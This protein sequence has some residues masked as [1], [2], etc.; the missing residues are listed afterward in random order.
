[1]IERDAIETSRER[2]WNTRPLISFFATMAFLFMIFFFS[3]I[4]PFSGTSGKSVLISDLS[5]QYAPFLVS[6]RNSILHGRSLT[7]SFQIGMGKNYLG[8]FAYYLSSPI[9]LVALLFPVSHISDAIV[10]IITLK[11]SL[12][13]AFM[14]WLLDKRFQDKTKM[15]ILFGS[16]YALCSFALVFMMNFMW[17]DGFALLPLVILV[18]EQFRKDTRQWWKVFIVLTILF[19][20]GYYMAYM[21]GVFSFFYLIAL[22]DYEGFFSKDRDPSGAKV[23][24]L[25]VLAAVFAA[26]VCA[27]MLIPAGLDTIY[28][29]D[30]SAATTPSVIP[31]F[32]LISFLPQLFLTRL[33]DIADNPPFIYAD[34]ATLFLVILFF[35]N[36]E[37]SSRLKRWCGIA[38]GL[39]V[40]SFMLPPLDIAWQLFDEPN[41][42]MHRYSYILTFG[43]ILI[44]FYSYLHRK[45]LANRDFAWTAGI[46]FLLLVL[47]ERFSAQENSLYYQT[48]AFSAAILLFLWGSTKEK[49]PDAIGNLKQIETPLLVLILVA[50]IA[51]LNPKTTVG[52]LFSNAQK[53]QD[54]VTQVEEIQGLSDAIDRTSWARVEQEDGLGKNID[55]L[56]LAPYI[57]ANG[58]SSFSSMS[59][60]KQQ[61]F[62][63]QLG[64]RVNY[65]YFSAEHT[66]PILPA[67]SV[68]G[69]RYI[70]STDTDETSMEKV[71]SAEHYALYQNP[72]AASIAFI[73]ETEADL[74]D[75]YQ[76]EKDDITKDYFAFQEKWLTSLTGKA[77]EDLYTTFEPE[78]ELINVEPAPCDSEYLELDEIEYKDAMNLENEKSDSESIQ[79]YI[80]TNEKAPMVFRTNVKVEKNSPL[81]LSVPFLM[82]CFPYSVYC[83]GQKVF[84]EEASSNYSVIID[85]G[86]FEAGMD[87]QIE[88]RSNEDLFACLSPRL[89][90]VDR[91]VLSEQMNLLKQGVT[92]T[93][94]KDGRV[95]FS[96]E[97]EKESLVITTIPFEKNW[98]VTVDGKKVDVLSYQDAF[99]SFVVPEG[100]HQIAME[101]SLPGGSIGVIISVV[102]LLSGAVVALVLRKKHTSGAK[103]EKVTGDLK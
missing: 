20:S 55:S 43:M 39:G 97:T 7:Y 38:L 25:F 99:V 16:I 11:L 92:V 81:Y 78:W 15:S 75:F 31:N 103:N 30:H 52:N 88:I 53:N 36:K 91:A 58:I 50:E 96:A 79:Y 5:A 12:A 72:D 67:D 6:L 46:V 18:I 86:T 4:S 71:A 33:T 9:N 66:F 77:A 76:L 59:N 93:E 56:S 8:I 26:M 98:R 51:F 64:Y 94:V 65:N 82:R 27:A 47:I 32:S 35:K 48:I 34:L 1:M 68:L 62:L 87:V 42:Y 17:L 44:A 102:G 63:K 3:G 19:V 73:A 84:E 29:A 10:V 74:F 49:W 80:R 90:Y 57:D 100:T 54:F 69:I 70:L 24:G 101:F 40:L 22:L 21:V 41:W 95:S 37:I 61:R 89:A 23:L 83:N 2:K 60:K 45:A 13:G 14:T 28:N 85:L